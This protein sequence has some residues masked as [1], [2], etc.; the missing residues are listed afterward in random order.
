[1][2][3]LRKPNGLT[4]IDSDLHGLST[5]FEALLSPWIE[6]FQCEDLTG[7]FIH[8]GLASIRT[9]LH[10]GMF[11]D[12]ASPFS[13]HFIQDLV[14]TLAHS[15]FEPTNLENDEIVMLELIEFLAEFVQITVAAT[16]SPNY[17]ANY[18]SNEE[19]IGET[20]L[21]QLFDLLFVLLNQNRFSEL[22]RAKAVEIVV[23]LCSL[24]FSSLKKVSAW[25][26]DINRTS[27]IHFPNVVKPQKPNT[28]NSLQKATSSPSATNSDSV[29]N[30]NIKNFEAVVVNTP[31]SKMSE[32]EPA[33]VDAENE[34]EHSESKQA[35]P[36]DSGQSKPYNPFTDDNENELAPDV[37]EEVMKFRAKIAGISLESQ[38]SSSEEALESIDLFSDRLSSHALKQILL[39]LIKCIDIIDTPGKKAPGSIKT[40]TS[41]VA[42][43]ST[44]VIP[45]VKTQTAAMKCLIAIFT[46]PISELSVK[47]TPESISAFEKEL[48][49]MI[50]G[51]LLKQLLA[52]LSLDTSPRHLNSLS[53]L[54]IVIFT[55]YR[56]FLPAQFE[57][58]IS[59]CLGIISSKPTAPSSSSL[60]NQSNLVKT[61]PRPA[62]SALKTTCLEMISYVRLG[63]ITPL[64]L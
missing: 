19:L 10:S 27:T 50:G 18:I 2:V 42:N 46:D 60:S 30:V 34:Y 9:F 48:I 17:S 33:T 45:S 32:N 20:F 6:L 62:L 5:D 1:M 4:G 21:F 23:E 31:E 22:L 14:F 49:D 13:R 36:N 59:T 44:K 61:I 35:E 51:D 57:Y 12:S 15:R 39:Y 47:K 52:I 63:P 55:N 37:I 43:I 53:Q 56:S 64:S 38:D 41:A 58:F 28:L 24:L 29:V 54:L 8:S 7:A 16:K 40:D 25:S 26:Q 3:E 11:T